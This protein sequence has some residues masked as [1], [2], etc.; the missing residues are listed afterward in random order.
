MAGA[1]KFWKLLKTI[2]LNFNLKDFLSSSKLAS[3]MVLKI[4]CLIQTCIV[5]PV[6]LVHDKNRKAQVIPNPSF[7]QNKLVIFIRRIMLTFDIV[8]QV[9]AIIRSYYLLSHPHTDPKGKNTG[10]QTV[11]CLIYASLCTIGICGY[12]LVYF[13][14]HKACYLITQRFVIVPISHRNERSITFGDVVALAVASTMLSFP[15][16]WFLVPFVVDYDMLQT[17]LAHFLPKMSQ[18]ERN[19]CKPVIGII[20]TSLTAYFTGYLTFVF[21]LVVLTMEGFQQFSNLIC[22]WNRFPSQTEY[23]RKLHKFRILQISMDL[24][25]HILEKPIMILVIL[26]TV[27]FSSCAYTAIKLYKDLPVPVV[28]SLIFMLLVV[29]TV[30]V[31]MILISDVISSNGNKFVFLWK[32]N[33]CRR[34]FVEK[35]QIKSCPPVGYNIGPVKHVRR[36]NGLQII[37]MMISRTLDMLLLS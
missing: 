26:G 3:P 22:T 20:Y 2:C 8:C 35:R 25:N 18:M 5:P 17:L 21:C 34:Y 9:F 23:S 24:C 16:F 11:F 29:V 13:V 31:V 37:D 1:L 6:S 15:L 10:A 4:G 19:L 36:Y 7:S 30:D 32:R 12:L 14:R 27:L 33:I 28:L